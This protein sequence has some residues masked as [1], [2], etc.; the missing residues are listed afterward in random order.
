I[1][2]TSLTFLSKAGL[3]NGVPEHLSLQKGIVAVESCRGLSKS[4]MVLNDY[5]PDI[6]VDPE[7]YAVRVDGEVITCEPAE[8]L[9]MA[10]RYF[11]F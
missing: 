2:S 4:D 3:E 11:L 8:S 10:Q 7:T 9:P 5:L 6:E 1:G